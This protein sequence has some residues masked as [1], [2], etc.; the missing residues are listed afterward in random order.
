M[1]KNPTIPRGTDSTNVLQDGPL[2]AQPARPVL[3]HSRRPGYDFV[4][5]QL[6]HGNITDLTRTE[7][8]G[9]VAAHPGS[10]LRE[11]A[12]VTAEDQTRF[13]LTTGLAV[14]KQSMASFVEQE[15]K[16][17]LAGQLLLSITTQSTFWGCGRQHS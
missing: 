9:V 6:S 1:C 10:V 11:G 14:T 5:D 4:R 8:L 15:I 3:P 7:A 12:A 17:S 16:I 2:H 13:H